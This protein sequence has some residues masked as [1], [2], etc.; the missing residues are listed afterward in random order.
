MPKSLSSVRVVFVLLVCAS[1]APPRAAAPP[2]SATHEAPPPPFPSALAWT[3]RPDV[4]VVTDEGETRVPHAFTRLNVLHADTIGVRVRCLYCIP[5]LEGS[6]A[7]EDVVHEALTPGAASHGTLAEFAL[8]VRHAAEHRD[9]RALQ[10][11]MSSDFTFSFGGGGGPGSA[12][13]RWQ[14]EGFRSLDHLPPL[15]DRGLATRDSVIWVAPPAFLSDPEY[16]G[17]RT[18]FRRNGAGQWEW[19]FLVSGG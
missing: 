17:L 2:A 9:L 4:R 18:G 11:V 10:G 13:I 12:L 16:H 14:W 19:I 5:A 3:A 1:C 8:A 7:R 15:L 6:L